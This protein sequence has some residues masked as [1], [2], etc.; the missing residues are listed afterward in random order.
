MILTDADL[1]AKVL[2]GDL[3]PENPVSRV[4]TPAV[5]VPPDRLAVDAVVDMLAAGADHL[6]VVDEPPAVLGIVSAVSRN[7]PGDYLSRIAAIYYFP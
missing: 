2:A 4:T 5:T 1:R 3:S 7:S 6:V